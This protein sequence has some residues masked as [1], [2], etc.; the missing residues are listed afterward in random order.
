[1]KW[2]LMPVAA[3]AVVVMTPGPIAHA[4]LIGPA[5]GAEQPLPV[6]QN[7][8]VPGYWIGPAGG[9]PS[10]LTPPEPLPNTIGPAGALPSGF[11]LL[12]PAVPESSFMQDY[13]NAIQ[14]KGPA[15]NACYP[16]NLRELLLPCDTPGR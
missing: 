6:I 3:L 12:P 8:I 16:K 9:T 4:D 13:I 11:P 1:M 10:G 15:D 2:Y 7:P 5:G 14:G